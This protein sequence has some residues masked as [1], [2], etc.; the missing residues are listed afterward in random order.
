MSDGIEL[1]LKLREALVA[2]NGQIGRVV[3]EGRARAIQLDLMF[4]VVSAVLPH[5]IEYHNRLEIGSMNLMMEPVKIVMLNKLDEN[6]CR[7]YYKDTIGVTEDIGF[8][9]SWLAEG[10][11]P[12]IEKVK[13]EKIANLEKKADKLTEQLGRLLEEIDRIKSL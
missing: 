9:I 13:S 4:D 5:I 7:L 8:K 10:P 2:N 6:V 12:D 11:G 3:V 1:A